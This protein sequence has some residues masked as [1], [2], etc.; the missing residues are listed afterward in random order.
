MSDADQID[1]FLDVLL[2]LGLGAAVG[3]ERELRDRRAGIRTIGLVCM[4]AAVFALVSETFS[5]DSRVAAG[6]VQGIGFIGAGIVFQRGRDV[7]GL[8]TAATVWVMAGV[9]L[10][11]GRELRLLAVLVAVSTIVALETSHW[12]DYFADR[13]ALRGR[14]RAR[15]REGEPRADLRERPGPDPR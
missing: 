12:Y 11:V 3:L 13:R 4:G 6:V 1:L 14:L 8:T 15:R 5:E 9:G 10:L 2:A 7:V